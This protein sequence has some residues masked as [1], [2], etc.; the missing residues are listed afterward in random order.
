[1]GTPPILSAVSAESQA[2]SKEEE[3]VHL[4]SDDVT[5]AVT[6]YGVL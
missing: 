6:G 5:L 3:S 4:I 2:M 1:M